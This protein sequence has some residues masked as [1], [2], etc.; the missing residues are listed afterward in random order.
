MKG[1]DDR[2]R[3]PAMKTGIY[4][5]RGLKKLNRIFYDEKK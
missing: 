2:I 5:K 4:Y 3:I 1:A